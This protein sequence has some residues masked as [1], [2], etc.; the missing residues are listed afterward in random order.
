MRAHHGGV[1]ARV[2]VGAQVSGHMQDLVDCSALLAR[3]VG[4][5]KPGAVSIA[6]SVDDASVDGAAT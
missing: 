2:V 6:L 1:R 5:F 3:A 4:I